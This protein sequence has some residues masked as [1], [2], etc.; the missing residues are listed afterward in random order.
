MN[1]HKYLH[2]YGQNNYQSYKVL[3]KK[4]FSVPKDYYYENLYIKEN[5]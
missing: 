2:E 1:T 4:T 3:N 5:V